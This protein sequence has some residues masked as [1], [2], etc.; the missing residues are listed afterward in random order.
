MGFG[1]IVTMKNGTA[2]VKV[3]AAKIVPVGLLEEEV[4]E[5][6]NDGGVLNAPE[7]SITLAAVGG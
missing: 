2:S 6:I 1:G 3:S 5:T 7:T 4:V